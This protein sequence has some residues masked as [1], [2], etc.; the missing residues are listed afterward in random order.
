MFRTHMMTFIIIR[1]ATIAVFLADCQIT[2][3][4]LIAFLLFK[5]Q[6]LAA[7]AHATSFS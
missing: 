2:S 6:T 4:L 5:N 3:I 1:E 7:Y